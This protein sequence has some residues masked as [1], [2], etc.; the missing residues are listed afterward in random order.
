MTDDEMVRATSVLASML[1]HGHLTPETLAVALAAAC[2]SMPFAVHNDLLA[3]SLALAGKPPP[4]MGKVLAILSE[5]IEDAVRA[6]ETERGD[7]Q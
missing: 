6:E 1:R 5:A 7:L 4:D 3:R 2:S